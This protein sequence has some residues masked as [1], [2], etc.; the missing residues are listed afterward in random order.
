MQPVALQGGTVGGHGV[1]LPEALLLAVPQG[2]EPFHLH[3]GVAQQRLIPGMRRQLPDEGNG[4][5]LV[6]HPLKGMGQGHE[7]MLQ[8]IAH[9]KNLL[10]GKGVHEQLEIRRA[11]FAQ[12]IHGVLHGL[13][14]QRLARCFIT[15]AR[16]GINARRLEVPPKHRLAKTMDGGNLRLGQEV[17]LPCPAGFL[18]RLLAQP[19][20]Q[21]LAHFRR[22]RPGKGYNKHPVQGSALPQQR[23]NPL[24]QHRC[25]ARP[26]RR[27]DE[28]RSV[29][30]LDGLLLLFRPLGHTT[31]SLLHDTLLYII[32]R[33]KQS[34]QD[35]RGGFSEKSPSRALPKSGSG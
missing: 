23:H 11:L 3:G 13:L 21:P 35:A 5:Q 19:P 9:V 7:E 22:R 17:Q 1:R 14:E 4:V 25:F 34:T 32:R 10:L 16:Q 24:H 27:A 18:F 6:L 31:A 29:P 33:K 26:R 2:H 12:I 28:Q 15:Y 8:A 20:V 30:G